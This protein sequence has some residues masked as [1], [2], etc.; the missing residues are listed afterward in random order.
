MHTIG[1]HSHICQREPKEGAW[2]RSSGSKGFRTRPHLTVVL[3]QRRSPLP[4]VHRSRHFLTGNSAAKWMLKNESYDRF[5]DQVPAP[6]SC[7]PDYMLRVRHISS[8]SGHL[9]LEDGWASGV[10]LV[11][12]RSACLQRRGHRR[13]GGSPCAIHRSGRLIVLI[14]RKPRN[15][16]KRWHAMTKNI[17]PCTS[18]DHKHS[19]R[20]IQEAGSN[21]LI[22]CW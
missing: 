15:S 18:D 9:F 19:Y 13:E 14:I 16:H 8:T 5:V 2:L 22:M 11:R 4:R 20:L 12:R 3:P 17:P 6:F 7:I 1:S 21:W 10:E